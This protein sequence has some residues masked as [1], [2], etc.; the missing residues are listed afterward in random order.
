MT[1]LLWGVPSESPV[2]E[3]A[4]KVGGVTALAPPVTTMDVDVR[5]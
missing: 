5:P 2:G 4:K 3:L 1:V